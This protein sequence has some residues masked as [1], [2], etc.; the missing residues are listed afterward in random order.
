MAK[1]LNPIRKWTPE[2]IEYLWLACVAATHAGIP[3]PVTEISQKMGRNRLSVAGRLQWLRRERW[4]FNSWPTEYDYM[5]L[6]QTI[7]Q[8]A[9]AEND[10]LILGIEQEPMP[11]PTPFEKLKAAHTQ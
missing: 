4:Q 10:N 3:V 9:R 5:A 7:K 1:P 6:H 8:R 11:V 2:E